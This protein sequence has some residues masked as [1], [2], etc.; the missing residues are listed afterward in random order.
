MN[1]LTSALA[2]LGMCAAV[3]GCVTTSQPTSTTVI[4]KED[5]MIASGFRFVPAN[6]PQRQA[7]FRTLPPHKFTRQTRG[8]KT[9]YAYAD[10]TICVCLYVGN[11]SNY[12][13]YRARVFDQNI[14]NEQVTIAND[15]YYAPSW[16]WSI[17]GTEYPMGWPY[18]Y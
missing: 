1:R 9:V 18:N 11:P 13:A 5:M 14:A 4:N 6:T 16:D 10:P 17:W 15:Y 7:A 8:D 3:A 12:A 2:V